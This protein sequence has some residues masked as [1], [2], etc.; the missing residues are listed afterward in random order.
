MTGALRQVPLGA[1]IGLVMFIQVQVL[2]CLP[3]AA[4]SI[5]LRTAFGA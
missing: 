5:G 3:I 1:L 4:I 2:H